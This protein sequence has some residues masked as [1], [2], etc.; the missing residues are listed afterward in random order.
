MTLNLLAIAAALLAV[1][2]KVDLAARRAQVGIVLQ[3]LGWVLLLSSSLVEQGSWP[4]RLL[5]TLAMA[6]IAGGLTCNAIAFD[7]WYGRAAVARAPSVIAIVMT[8]GYGIGYGD[9]AFRVGWAN[10]WLTLQLAIV[11]LALCRTPPAP[12]GRWRWRC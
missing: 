10:G 12:V 7:L 9:Y 5:S 3:A 6:G 11:V 8:L 4:D 2:G 1:M